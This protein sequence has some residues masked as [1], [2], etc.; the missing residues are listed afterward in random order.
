MILLIELHGL[1]EVCGK[2]NLGT[3][4]LSLCCSVGI[5][6]LG[7]EALGLCEDIVIQVGQHGGVE[8]DVVLDEQYHLH[9][10]FLDIVL[11]VHL[12]LEQL[13]DRHDQVGVS[14]PTEHVVEHR[15]ILVFYSFGDT[16][17]ER[18]EHHAWYIRM[19]CLNLSGNSKGIVI[20]ITRHTYHEIHI[21]GLHHRT[22]LFRR[23]H[24]CERWRVAHSQFHI[25]VEDLLVYSSVVLEHECIVGISHDEDIEDTPCHKI[26][27]RHVL[28][29]EFIPRLWYFVS[30][31]HIRLQ[32]YKKNL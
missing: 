17:R 20:G 23:R 4:S 16:M 29:I 12:V 25:L 13:D 3:T 27:E 2:H 21:G 9:T 10:G 8:A 32:R 11:D 15:H 18:C 14:Q 6:G 24:L 26:D 7:G 19:G 22:G 28:Q 30:F 31:F 1:L 5:E